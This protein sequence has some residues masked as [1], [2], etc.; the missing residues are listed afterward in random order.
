MSSSRCHGSDPS[1]AAAADRPSRSPPVC[2][3]QPHPR[4]PS[5]PP[6][7]AEAPARSTWRPSPPSPLSRR[8]VWP[9]TGKSTRSASPGRSQRSKRSG[10]TSR[11]PR[12]GGHTARARPP[13]NRPRR[14]PLAP[15]P[16]PLRP[17]RTG[18]LGAPLSAPRRTRRPCRSPKAVRTPRRPLACRDR[19]GKTRWLRCKRPCAPPALAS[20]GASEH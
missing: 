2:P 7:A 15:R 6:S 5:A 19:T 3:P 12:V 20:H 8:G 10:Q 13:L 4:D 14:S 1:R 11:D 16:R 18:V 9:G 17:P